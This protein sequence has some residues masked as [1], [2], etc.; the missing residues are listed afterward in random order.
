MERRA[1]VPLRLVVID[2]TLAQFPIGNWNDPADVTRVTNAMARIAGET[3]AAVLGVHHH[4]KDVSRGP[5]G[6]YALTAAA[7]FILSVL[8]DGDLEGN[9]ANRRVAL[10]KQRE[11]STGWGSEFS[12]RPFK[13]G[14]D[15]YGEDVICAFVEP[16]EGS[17]GSYKPRNEKARRPSASTAAFTKA[18]AAAIE[19][20]GRENAAGNGATKRVVDVKDVRVAF[21]ESY[22]PNC[23][24]AHHEEARRKAFS[25]ALQ[26]AV[27]AGAVTEVKDGA[28]HWLARTE[29]H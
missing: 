6:S 20:R 19:T 23:E 8:C 15:E 12:L 11:G 24:P 21:A 28:G 18:L 4:G 13:V 16:V 5:A 27:R 10:T 1:G 9:V 14:V 29:R 22:K 25:R 3:G 17:A 26:D 2:T 7:D